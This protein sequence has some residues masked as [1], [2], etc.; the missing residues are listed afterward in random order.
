MINRLIGSINELI[1]QSMTHV[2]P[3]PVGYEFVIWASHHTASISRSRTENR[4]KQDYWLGQLVFIR[5]IHGLGISVSQYYDRTILTDT[6]LIRALS[7][8]DAWHL[9]TNWTFVII[10][11]LIIR[12]GSFLPV[13]FR[14]QSTL[15]SIS[16]QKI[17]FS[18]IF[19]Q[20][21]H[22]FQNFPTKLTFFQNF[23]TRFTFFSVFCNKN[24][25]FPLFHPRV[26]F[27]CA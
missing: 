24:L 17:T 23:P 10:H 27:F 25:G 11:K 21:W 3:G 4:A 13:F 8:C 12:A 5:L 18:R 1:G 9:E 16:L 26:H 14:T 7:Q 22:F 6:Y 19:L 2:K 20:I 15:F